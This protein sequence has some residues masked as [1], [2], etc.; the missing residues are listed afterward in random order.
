MIVKQRTRSSLAAA[1]SMALVALGATFAAVALP[2]R[3]VHALIVYDPTNYSQNLLTA[4]R[5][6]QQ[7]N[8]QIKSLQNEAQSLLNQGKN[9]TTIGFPEL[10]ALTQTLQQIDVL[11]GQA[12]G[13][14][15]QVSTLNQQFRQ[16]Y[17]TSNGSLS[18]SSQV[19]AA[20]ARLDTEMTAYQHTMTVQAQVVENIQ[21][22]AS[23]LS[24]MVERSQNAEGALQASQAT[25]QLLALTAKQQFQIQQLLAAQY[26]ADTLERAN[27]AQAT[28]A[29]QAATAKFLGTGTA[30]TPN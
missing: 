17:P 4:A 19:S 11:M 27:R 21:S 23:A 26:R 22:D 2:S 9:L 15:F 30:Y 3:P 24:A 14:Q 20:R 25:N 13:I 18:L 7:V 29:A 16:L 6:L 1:G 8:N 28:S 10:Q 12:Q 5:T